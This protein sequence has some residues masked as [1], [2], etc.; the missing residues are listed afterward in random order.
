MRRFFRKKR[1]FP[2]AP[3]IWILAVLVAGS[4]FPLCQ[5]K[6]LPF[7][8][9]AKKKGILFGSA[10]RARAIEEDPEYS[11]F[12]AKQF[13]ILTPENDFK[14]D[15]LHPEESRFDFTR[16]DQIVA[17]AKKHRQL[18]RGH[19]LVWHNPEA[20]PDW[21]K[22]PDRTP[23]ELKKL[24]QNHI[25]SVLLH[26]SKTAN[27]VVVSWDVINEAFDEEGNFR[28]DSIWARIEPDGFKF[29]S[30]VYRLS[31]RIA[32]KLKL[33]YNDY[34]IEA[35]GKKTEA[36]FRMMRRLK[37]AGVPIHGIGFQTHG[38]SGWNTDLSE[39][40]GI[41]KRFDK[42]GLRITISEMD[43]SIPTPATSTKDL[44]Q[45]ARFYAEAMKACLSVKSCQAFITWGFTDRTLWEENFKEG[46]GASTYLDSEM[47]PK[48]AFTAIRRALSTK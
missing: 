48:P 7:R 22:N 32:P 13:S 33:Y 11:K 16:A 1:C 40:P 39:F 28:Q 25:K 12:A 6:E 4:A 37:Q 10:I 26:F 20:L 29:F 38:S 24:L 42:L 3:G 18:V 14:F 46:L 45:Q 9:L 15:A 19:T 30:W 5:A 27:G 2:T 44:E 21:V 47:K 36:V 8:T 31:H 23:A 34:G 35:P 43:Y 41:L 17:F